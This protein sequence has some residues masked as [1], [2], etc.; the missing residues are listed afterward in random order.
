MRQKTVAFK[1]LSTA[2]FFVK[3][4]GRRER[5]LFFKTRSMSTET[6]TRCANLR[7]G[8][9]NFFSPGDRVIPVDG[10]PRTATFVDGPGTD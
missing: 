9:I 3:G 2:T 6:W 10:I 8:E 7:T 1:E 4:R 5:T